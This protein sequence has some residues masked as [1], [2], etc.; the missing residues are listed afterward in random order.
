M[1][2][3]HVIGADAERFGQGR[4]YFTDGLAVLGPAPGRSLCI[5]TIQA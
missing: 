1:A 4:P 2:S 3:Q 5:H